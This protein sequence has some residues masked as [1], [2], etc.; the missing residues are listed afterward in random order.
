MRRA[1]FALSGTVTGL[2]LLLSFKTHPAAV[3]TP[4]AAPS[5]PAPTGSASDPSASP[6]PSG[7]GSASGSGTYTGT[8][9][10]TRFGPVQVQITVTDG[11]VSAVQG[12]DYPQ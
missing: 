7:S 12:V 10:D 5:T 3:T 8:A 1:L 6:S 4:P 9:A 2:V 11:T